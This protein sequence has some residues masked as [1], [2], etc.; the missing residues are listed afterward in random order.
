MGLL[1]F[2]H[3]AWQMFNLC[4]RESSVEGCIPPTSR[5][6]RLE[7]EKENLGSVIFHIIEEMF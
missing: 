6:S 5:W 4:G 3:N 1:K 2:T 7:V